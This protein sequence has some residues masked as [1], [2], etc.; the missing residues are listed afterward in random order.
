MASIIACTIRSECMD[1]I[2]SNYE[3]QEWPNKEMIII[4]NKNSMSL[5]KWR[6]KAKEYDNVRVYKLPERYNLGKCLNWAIARAKG[7]FIAKFDDDDYYGPHYMKES[8]IALKAKKAPI[9]GKRSTYLYFEENKALMEYRAGNEFK[10]GRRI[11]GGTLFFRKSVWKH[12]KFPEE[13]VG[14]S[15]AKWLRACDEAGYKV[16]AVSKENYVCIRRKNLQSHTQKKPP[17]NY[18]KQCK[19]IAYTDDYTKLA[20]VDIED[21]G[22]PIKDPIK[23]SS[24]PPTPQGF[25]W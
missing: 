1:N 13:T 4:L 23:M 17:E 6:K 20:T 19:H 18:M 22:T 2:F 12:V 14:G 24:F 16:Y 5:K 21:D 15:D 7:T 10:E 9:I 3:R 8:L 25:F 11:K